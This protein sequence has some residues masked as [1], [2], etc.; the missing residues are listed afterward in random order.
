MSS[1]VFV[2]MMNLY[3]IFAPNSMFMMEY[4]D[5]KTLDK[6]YT[7]P[8]TVQDLLQWV[9]KGYKIEVVKLIAVNFVTTVTLEAIVVMGFTPYWDKWVEQ[10]KR[11]AWKDE[12]DVVKSKR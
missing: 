7:Y 6:D 2:V 1:C 12:M 8:E 9:Q 10:K 11:Q 4:I 5:L 3:F